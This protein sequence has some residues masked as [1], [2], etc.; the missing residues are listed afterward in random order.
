MHFSEEEKKNGWISPA[1]C[2]PNQISG[3]S[4]QRMTQEA[5]L[6]I[7]NECFLSA[8]LEDKALLFILQ[9]KRWALGQNVSDGMEWIEGDDEKPLN[10]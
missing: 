7:N 8:E 2:G 10:C 4:L 6:I 1:R 3:N 9:I 5:N